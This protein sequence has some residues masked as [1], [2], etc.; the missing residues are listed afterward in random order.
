MV[1]RL[2]RGLAIAMTSAAASCL[3]GSPAQKASTPAADIGA[4]LVA[5]VTL[6]YERPDA[7]RSV[8]RPESFRVIVD[9]ENASREQQY[10]GS[11]ND[12]T[13]TLSASVTVPLHVENLV[14]VV[15]P[16]VQ[17]G[18]TT[19]ITAARGTLKE[20]TCPESVSALYTCAILQVL[21]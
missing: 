3:S 2:V 9:F 8:G 7:F 14:Y 11:W 17:P 19:T 21:H 18:A 15:D 20:V 10:P 16:A 1:A 6:R 13:Q 12:A 5:Q 4:G